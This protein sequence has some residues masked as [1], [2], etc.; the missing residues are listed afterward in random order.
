MSNIEDERG[1]KD[2]LN[3]T[4]Y[5]IGIIADYFEK[6][7]SIKANFNSRELS[8]AFY[9]QIKGGKLKHITSLPFLPIDN[10]VV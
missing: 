4:E 8:D 2:G 10:C 7:Q 6:L 5:E 9:N 3:L 1:Y